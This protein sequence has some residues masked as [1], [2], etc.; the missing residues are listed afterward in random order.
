MVITMD[1]FIGRKLDG[2]YELQRVVGV[3][4]MAVVYRALDLLTS[5]PVA[6]KMLKPEYLDNEEVC[7]RFRNESKAIAMLKHKNIVKIFDVSDGSDYLFIVMEYI[8]GI[9]LKDYIEQQRVLTWR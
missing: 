4:G 1:Q 6:V 5:M 8:N 3:G 7:R 2:R 9:T